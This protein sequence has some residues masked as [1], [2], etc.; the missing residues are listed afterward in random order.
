[1][2]KFSK[3]Y[4][5]YTHWKVLKNGCSSTK[6][7][8]V[9][10]GSGQVKQNRGAMKRI[11]QGTFEVDSTGKSGDER[12]EQAQWTVCSHSSLTH[13]GDVTDSS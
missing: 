2:Y 6:Q 12:K 13:E 1:M 11:Y 5:P 7:R 8:S 10:R 9:A 3:C 4:F